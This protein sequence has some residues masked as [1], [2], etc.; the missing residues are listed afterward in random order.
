MISGPGLECAHLFPEAL[1]EW[2]DYPEASCQ[3]KWS[4]L[5]LTDSFCHRIHDIRLVAVRLVSIVQNGLI[6]RRSGISVRVFAPPFPLSSRETTLPRQSIFPRDSAIENIAK[7]ALR[8]YGCWEYVGIGLAQ[9]WC[10]RENCMVWTQFSVIRGGG[11]KFEDWQKCYKLLTDNDP[12]PL[13]PIWKATLISQR[14]SLAS[15]RRKLDAKL[16]RRNGQKIL[17]GS[18]YVQVQPQ[19]YM[20]QILWRVWLSQSIRMAK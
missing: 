13:P 11:R 10:I 6:F 2:Y 9:G 3:E 4:P 1:L 20:G 15:Q 12:Y 19:I 18:K 16:I 17:H 5:M 7:M 14:S 8:L